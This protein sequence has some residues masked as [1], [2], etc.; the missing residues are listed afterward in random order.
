MTKSVEGCARDQRP[1]GFGTSA[2]VG[3]TTVGGRRSE[4]GGGGYATTGCGTYFVT[5][6]GGG[7]GSGGWG[8]QCAS[9]KWAR[10]ASSMSWA[11]S[12]VI[13]G[14]NAANTRS[15]SCGRGNMN[16]RRCSSPPEFGLPL[17]VGVVHGGHLPRCF[18]DAGVRIPVME[19]REEP[20]GLGKA[21][22][23]LPSRQG[24]FVECGI[25]PLFA[26]E[27]GKGWVTPDRADVFRPLRARGRARP[28]AAGDGTASAGTRGRLR[29]S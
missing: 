1:R 21:V 11:L 15:R 27:L 23:G 29:G 16:N 19:R 9:A 4:A 20:I 10:S 5:G 2:H 18:L 24:K 17:A 13:S 26:D 6:F 12:C 8:C 25:Q 14:Q 7:G 28:A 22:V 3:C